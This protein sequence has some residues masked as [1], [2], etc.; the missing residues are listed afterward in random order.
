[1][2]CRGGYVVLNVS[3]I[4]S[5]YQGSI[6]DS[7]SEKWVKCAVHILPLT[8]LW[9]Q[10]EKQFPVQPQITILR[11]KHITFMPLIAHQCK[12]IWIEKLDNKSTV[13]TAFFPVLSINNYCSGNKGMFLHFQIFMGVHGVQYGEEEVQV[14]T[15]TELVHWTRLIHQMYSVDE[16]LTSLLQTPPSQANGNKSESKRQSSDGE[17][18]RKR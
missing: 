13:C 16:L 4:H 8:P 2:S 9:L 18:R 6:I 5:D 1:M 11:V 10:N 7:L 14:H 3:S 15:S 12:K 17:E